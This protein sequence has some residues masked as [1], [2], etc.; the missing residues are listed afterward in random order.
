[1]I[2]AIYARKSNEQH[3]VTDEQKS[4]ARQV[5]HARQY[6]RDNGWTVDESSI[7]VDDG[8]SGAE[9]AGRPGFVALM[10]ALK[11]KPRFGVLI[12]S[13][14]SRLGR[15][16]IETA[17]AMKQLSVAGVR[18]FSYLER[19]E[20]LLESAVD[21]FL[22]SAVNLGAELEREKARLRTHDA[23]LRKARAGHVTGGEPFGYENVGVFDASGRRSHVERRIKKDEAV[24][25]VRIFEL[26]AS[27]YGYKAIARLLNAEGCLTP[28]AK[29]GR[30]LK[31]AISSVCEVLH[32]KSYLG[33]LT[34]NQTRYKNQWG[35][36]ATASASLRPAEEWVK[37]VDPKLRI[38]SD[39]LWQRTHARLATV[40]QVY[41]G[42]DRANLP[43]RA[44]PA[45]Y[46]LS[47]L[48]QCGVC[49]GTLWTLSG[50]FYA[51]R[52]IRRFYGCAASH[53]RG[54]CTN[55]SRLPVPVADAHVSE[56]L[57]QQLL[58][59]PF[60]LD[61]VNATLALL[62]VDTVGDQ[63]KAIEAELRKVERERAK[64]V[65]AIGSAGARKVSGLL[66][67]LHAREQRLTDLES[68]RERL[69]TVRP[70]RAADLPRTRRELL[71]R[72][73]DWRTRLAENDP[74]HARPIVAALLDGRLTIT[75]KRK[76]EWEIR[77]RGTLA[78]LFTGE[79]FQSGTSAQLASHPTG[80]SFR[81]LIRAV[82]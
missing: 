73:H 59:E 80:V 75:P 51:D 6:A 18:C 74:Q 5:D 76:D 55:K 24:V 62:R 47:N 54:E 57:M 3:G 20:L 25:V 45:K 13:E 16:Q 64:Y 35:V 68:A 10:N 82:A 32:R 79:V 58:N 4:V 60:I 44:D 72:A 67:A 69:R 7:F 71:E 37:H 48:A 11:P 77:G 43:P 1:M 27:G 14:L 8:I 81:H 70:F 30:A 22:L 66:D 63:L 17:Y 52:T 9:F 23:L 12:M 49:G 36:R 26:S 61:A 38:I 33:L 2:A 21:K 40:R 28:R 46:L 56:A 50:G 19:R 34:W 53:A 65:S 29:G 42:G 41:A 31:W 39:D 15:E 78:G